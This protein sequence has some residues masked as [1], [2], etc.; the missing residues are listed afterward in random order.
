[1]KEEEKTGTTEIEVLA[2]RVAALEQEVYRI[3]SPNL[4]HV[5]LYGVIA[6]AVL[7]ILSSRVER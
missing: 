7:L 1:M 2:V 3:E 5:F 6:G 4:F